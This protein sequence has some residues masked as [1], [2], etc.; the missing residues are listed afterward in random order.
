MCRGARNA[1]AVADQDTTTAIGS[2]YSFLW[3]D[4][5]GWKLLETILIT[6]ILWKWY[7][8]GWELF[9]FINLTNILVMTSI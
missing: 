3:L 4:F 6:K 7:H 2:S 1:A 5:L 8:Y 9:I